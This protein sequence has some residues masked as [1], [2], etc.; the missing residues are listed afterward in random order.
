MLLSQSSTFQRGAGLANNIG[1][2]I[3]GGR[4]GAFDNTVPKTFQFSLDTEQKVDAIRVLFVN[5]SSAATL[6]IGGA[7][8]LGKPNWSAPN[9]SSGTLS[10]LTFGGA[11]TGTVPLAPGA[12]RGY[13][14]SDWI[15]LPHVPR[16][17]GQA[18]SIITVAAYVSTAA[19]ITILG[20]G[21]SDNYAAWATKPSRKVMMRYNDGDCIT[22]PANFT[23]T[24]NRIQSPIIGIQYVARGVVRNV[25]AC[26]DSIT[27]GRGTYIGGSFAYD[28]CTTISDAT[29]VA[30]EYSNMAWAGTASNTYM[31]LLDEALA[32]LAGY[33]P[34]VAILPN[35]S[36]NDAAAAPTQASVDAGAAR[37]LRMAASA[38]RQGVK[39]LIWTGIPT[40]PALYNMGAADG[41]RV[42]KN[43]ETLTEWAARGL[44]VVDM[45]TPMSGTIAGGQ[46][47]IAAGLSADNIHPNDAGNTVMAGVLAPK[48]K[49]MLSVV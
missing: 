47:P 2:R 31:T 12:R 37:A 4:V 25:L 20:N 13:L 16:D 35:Y 17:D 26:G 15:T 6:S 27:D 5:G 19:S 41:F 24:T 39:P 7:R 33:L 46:Y 43:A 36:P 34:H 29:K 45:A 1:T 40:N 8:A 11:A 42:A 22:T 9:I 49:Q 14:W 44:D 48:L 28:A 10:A 21:G 38:A 23:S 3:F 18:G 30:V 32:A